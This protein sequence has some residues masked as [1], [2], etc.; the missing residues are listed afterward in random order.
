MLSLPRSLSIKHMGLYDF[1]FLQLCWKSHRSW[2][3]HSTL[4]PE[5]TVQLEVVN[6]QRVSI[7]SINVR[8]ALLA[9]CSLPF[10]QGSYFSAQPSLLVRKS[11]FHLLIGDFFSLL[12]SEGPCRRR[13]M[14][15]LLSLFI[16]CVLSTRWRFSVS[17]P[18]RWWEHLEY[19]KCQVF[20]FPLQTKATY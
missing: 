2:W 1:F 8:P 4:T 5:V 17:I 18:S 20:P 7:R 6:Q 11:G 13:H 9:S 15:S 19:S 12:C 14:S 10:Q 3:N 16:Y